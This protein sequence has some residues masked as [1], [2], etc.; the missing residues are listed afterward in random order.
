MPRRQIPDDWC[1]VGIPDNAVLHETAYIVSSECFYPYRSEQ[2]VGLEM[3]EGSGLYFGAML[4]VGPR[5]RIKLGRCA[6]IP[7][8]MF[9]CDELI[10]IGDHAL[11]SWNVVIMD[12]YRA[13]LSPEARHREMLRVPTREP[14]R[15][16][17]SSVKTRPVRIGNNVWIGFDCIVTPGVTIGDGSVVGCRSVVIDDVPPYSV[18][19]GNPARVIKSLPQNDREVSH[20]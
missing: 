1:D 18:V 6:L 10:E 20:A 3:A 12:S 11:I 8:V 14:R 4:D 13:P 15:F 9:I 7:A 5:G 17:E 19:A 2:E 16:D